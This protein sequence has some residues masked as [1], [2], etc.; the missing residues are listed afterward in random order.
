MKDLFV[1]RLMNITV[2]QGVARLD[3][4]RVDEVN[5]EDKKVKMSNSYRLAMPVDALA[6]LL[7]QSSK[8][9][10]EIKS[11]KDKSAKESIQ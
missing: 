4:A 1:D 5:T 6:A 9:L 10:E 3:F 2:L 8:A 11:M 7:E